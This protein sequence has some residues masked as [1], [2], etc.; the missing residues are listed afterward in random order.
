MYIEVL[1]WVIQQCT[2]INIIDAW[3][4]LIDN[5]I[6]ST[7]LLSLDILNISN[8]VCQL[9]TIMFMTIKL[10]NQPLGNV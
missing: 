8:E 6:Y 10:T 9:T 2:T 4:F 5:Y 7:C 1:I 3:I